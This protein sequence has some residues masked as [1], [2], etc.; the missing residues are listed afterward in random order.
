M[1]WREEVE[2]KRHSVGGRREDRDAFH[3]PLQ[4]TGSFDACV[5][6]LDASSRGCSESFVARRLRKTSAR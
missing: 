1:R 3:T 5:P 2:E 4:E 6:H